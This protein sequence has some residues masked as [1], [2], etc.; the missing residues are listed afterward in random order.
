M[1][2]LEEDARIGAGPESSCA[3]KRHCAHWS[4][5]LSAR[6]DVKEALLQA[7]AELIAEVGWG[8]VSS[9]MVAERAGVNNALV[10][11]HFAVRGA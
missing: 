10:H 7:A 5:R 6:P 4:P 2:L 9:R 3:E 11:Y 8:R 1:A